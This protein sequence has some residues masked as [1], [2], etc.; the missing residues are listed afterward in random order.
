MTSIISDGVTTI[1]PLVVDGYESGRESGNIVHR[2]IGV[3][4][5]DVTFRPALLR[6]GTLRLV[7]PVEADADA[8]VAFHA[9]GTVFAFEDSDRPSLAMSY[10]TSGRISCALDDET[11]DV[12]VVSVDYQE[13]G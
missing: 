6:A 9:A 11:R 8:A 2:I 1:T 5:P 13:V 3:A 12:W 10:V 4:S 7:F